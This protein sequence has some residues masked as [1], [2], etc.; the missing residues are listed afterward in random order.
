MEHG[1]V[2][3]MMITRQKAARKAARTRAINRAGWKRY[4]E[5]DRPARRRLDNLL[6]HFLKTTP[7]SVR[8]APLD[9]TGLRLKGGTIY[10]R[11]LSV[12]GMTVTVLPEGYKRPRGY[13]FQFWE[14]L[15]P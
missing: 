7:V 8:L 3:C 2:I 1:G 9:D 5:V 12:D 13:H 14:P 11:L 10:G 4:N 15:L 6:N